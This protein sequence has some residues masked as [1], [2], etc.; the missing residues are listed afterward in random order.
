MEFLNNAQLPAFV[1]V[2]G[3]DGFNDI[4]IIIIII[5]KNNNNNKNKILII[6]IIIR[7]HITRAMSE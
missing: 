3:N 2:T 1:R 7:R 4:I 5:K 6:I